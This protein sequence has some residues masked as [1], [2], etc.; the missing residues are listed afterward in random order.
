ME[1]SQSK[2]PNYL[3][4]GVQKAGTT[5]AINTFNSHPD[6]FM[7]DLELHFFDDDRKYKKGIETYETE[8]VTTKKFIGEKTPKYCFRQS[9]DRIYNHYPNIKLILILRNPVQRA[10]SQWNMYQTSTKH[11]LKNVKF[12]DCII[13]ELNKKTTEPYYEHDVL[14]RGYYI[15]IIEYILTKFKKEQLY[16]GIAERIIQ[17]YFDEYNKIFEFIGARK[18]TESE[19]NVNLDIHKRSYVEKI[20]IMDKELLETIYQPYN[21]KL[22]DFLGYKI[23]EWN[24][25]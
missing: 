17:N 7:H 16:I 25:D 23:D 19:M 11:V 21:E 12:R 5:S 24:N 6:I 8:F 20:N 1:K 22:Y 13:N 14:T 15:N 4:I 18:L 2:K 9:I 10:Y 3:L